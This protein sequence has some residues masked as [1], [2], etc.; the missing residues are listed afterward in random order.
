[1]DH[2]RNKLH[3]SVDLPPISDS[4]AG[5]KSWFGKKVLLSIFVV[6]IIIVVVVA[7]VLLPQSIAVLSLNV[8]YVVGEKMVYDIVVIAS[9]PEGDSL[10]STSQQSLEVIDFDGENYHLNHTITLELLNKTISNSFVQVMNKNGYS[11]S[12][13]GDGIDSSNLAFVQLLSRPEVKVGESI[14]IPYPNASPMIDVKGDL[15]IKFGGIEE[16]VVPAGTYTVFRIDLSASNVEASATALDIDVKNSFSLDYQVY[17]EYGTLRQIKAVTKQT[18]EYASPE[19]L[20]GMSVESIG[21]MTLVEH[22]KP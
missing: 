16:L 4:V 10:T 13:V 3:L 11:P 7:A 9:N 18:M 2:M 6:A 22:I 8:D 1:M 19:L 14:T 15:V 5:H 17:L 20:A 12:M 21:E